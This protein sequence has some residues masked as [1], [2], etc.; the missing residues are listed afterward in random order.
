MGFYSIKCIQSIYSLATSCCRI[1]EES[2]TAPPAPV[3][4]SNE[5]EHMKE[6]NFSY[7]S[8][9]S[10]SWSLAYKPQLE[11]AQEQHDDHEIKVSFF[12]GIRKQYFIKILFALSPE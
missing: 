6:D 8:A 5:E 3:V 4:R 7:Q 2:E 9:T 1:N 10:S 12:R 11:A